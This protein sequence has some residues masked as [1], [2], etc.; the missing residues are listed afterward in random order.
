[1]KRVLLTGATGLIGR[2]CLPTLL[3]KGYEVHT[4]SARA[5][6]ANPPGVQAHQADLLD[7]AQVAALLARVQPSHLLH[8]AWYTQP[9][10]YWGSLENIRWVQ[11]SLNLLQLFTAHGGRRVVMAGSCAEYDWSYGY[12]A[13][14]ITPLQPATMYGKAKHALQL[15]VDAFAEQAQISAAWGRIFFLYGPHEYPERLIAAVTRA[16]LQGQPARCSHGN[17]IRDFLY[18]QDAAD[19]FVALLESNVR[20]AVNIASGNPIRLRQL[21]YQIADSLQQRDLV[22]LGALPAPANEPPLL[23]AKIDR[24]TNEVGWRP[25][26]G[27]EVGLEQTVRWWKDVLSNE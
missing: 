9:G 20:G 12:C 17:Q 26:Y 3:A 19:A 7:P 23:V 11:A 8:L 25:A 16:L 4:V 14:Q 10:A 27:L 24:L 13:E 18:V 2:H 6:S 21:I 1:M 15:L 22:Q 5:A